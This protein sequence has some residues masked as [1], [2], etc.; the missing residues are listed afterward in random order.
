MAGV[1]KSQGVRWV[2]SEKS[3]YRCNVRLSFSHHCGP[4]SVTVDAARL[5]KP[6]KD[7]LARVVS[8]SLSVRHAFL[9][10][11][12]LLSAGQPFLCC[13]FF[14]SQ[15]LPGGGGEQEG[16]PGRSQFGPQGTGVFLGAPPG[17]IH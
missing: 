2:N 12:V 11:Q 14:S 8:D 13:V 10:P 7:F 3:A 17:G 15:T 16:R 9:V 6:A 4:L 1:D 5:G